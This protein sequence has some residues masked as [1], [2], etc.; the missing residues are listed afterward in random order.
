M[1]LG[2][3]NKRTWM[4]WLYVAVLCSLF[5]WASFQE[6]FSLQQIDVIRSWLSAQGDWA[7]IICIL[8]VVV[9]TIICI[10]ATFMGFVSGIV[11][12]LNTAI[13][14]VVIGANVGALATFWLTHIIGREVIEKYMTGSVGELDKRIAEHGFQVVAWIRL[15]PFLPY[16]I[17]NYAFGL[18]SVS[19]KDLIFGNFI[20]MLPWMFAFVSL[21][22]AATKIS[23][24]DP[25]AFLT[26]EI[27]GPFVFVIMLLCVPPL[28]KRFRFRPHPPKKG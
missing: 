4:F 27:W 26:P 21:G 1:H 19:V 5:V 23:F 28:F 2:K 24:K 10:P 25:Y 6:L 18:T 22:N 14:C 16:N 11:F 3:L 15:M 7:P 17:Q 20:G 8:F 12:D 13:I 9:G